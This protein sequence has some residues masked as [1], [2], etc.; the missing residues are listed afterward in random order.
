MSSQDSQKAITAANTQ[1]LATEFGLMVDYARAVIINT[2]FP[3]STNNLFI[4]VAKGRIPSARYADWKQDAGWAL[5]AQR[6]KSIKG[7]VVLR[8]QFQE[9]QDRRKRDIGNLEKASTDL[10][11]EHG[12]IEADDNTIVRGISM[13]WS[14]HITGARVEIIPI[15]KA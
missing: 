1:G 4:N 11:V 9:G 5:K 10:L 6:P 12:V 3:P 7:P 15:S 2:P 13:F 14:K 8:Y